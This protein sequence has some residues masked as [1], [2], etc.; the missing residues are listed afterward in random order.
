MSL[1]QLP[2][3]DV[4]EVEAAVIEDAE[5]VLA[6]MVD[7]TSTFLEAVSCSPSDCTAFTVTM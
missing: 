3:D 1:Y 7:M 6:E 5:V 4:L 2:P